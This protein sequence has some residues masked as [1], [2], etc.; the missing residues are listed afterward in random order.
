MDIKELNLERGFFQ[1]TVPYAWWGKLLWV[2]GLIMICSVAVSFDYV[3]IAALG[4]LL[5]ALTAPKSF[6]TDLREIRKNA[7]ANDELEAQA[8]GQGLEIESW[9]WG[10]SSLTPTNDPRDWVL[11]APGPSTWDQNAYLPHADGSP[12]PE[13]PAKVGTPH[14]ATF[15]TYGVM[16]ALFVL[17]G[18]MLLYTIPKEERGMTVAGVATA[19]TLIWLFIALAKTRIVRQMLDTPTSLVRSAAVGAG[20]LV[21]QV[22]PSPAG[23]LNVVVDGNPDRTVPLCLSFKWEYEVYVCR[24][25]TDSEGNTKTECNWRTVRGDEGS[26]PFILND[27]S[28]GMLIRPETFKRKDFG[29]F[30]KRWESNHAD[31]LLKSLGSELRAKLFSGGDVR[32]HRWT[33]YALRMGDPVFVQGEIKPRTNADIT[34]EGIDT[35]LQ[36]AIVEM[37]GEDATASKAMLSRGTELSIIG[38]LRSNMEMLI[39]PLI[40][41]ILAVGLFIL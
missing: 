17:I 29:G 23:V 18:G 27:G 1:L 6:E 11:A 34:A 28:G 5:I 20:E 38:S 33:I 7:Q 21:G 24:Q 3:A 39:L 40:G 31:T 16:M 41:S 19:A 13:H 9:F 22:R 30:R 35:T 2:V 4:W 14:P 32:K 26:L 12:L 15:T 8:L 25:V 36:N 10:R 37:V